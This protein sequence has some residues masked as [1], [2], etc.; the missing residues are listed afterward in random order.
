MICRI[1]MHCRIKDRSF[2]SL[3]YLYS[4]MSMIDMLSSKEDNLFKSIATILN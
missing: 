2:D 1:L 3:V 4:N